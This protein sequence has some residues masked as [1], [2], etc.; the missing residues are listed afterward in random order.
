M[1]S[2]PPRSSAAQ[3]RSGSGQSELR[4]VSGF[5]DDQIVAFANGLLVVLEGAS[6]TAQE[7]DIVLIDRKDLPS[8]GAG[9]TGIV[10]LAPAV[11]NAIF[12]ATGTRL[13]NMPM[14]VS[15]ELTSQRNPFPYSKI[16]FSMTVSG[17]EHEFRHSGRTPNRPEQSP[18][19]IR[20][21]ELL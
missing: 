5:N 18:W 6:A 21:C 13:R 14:A 4:S 1:E 3:R 8:A 11:S 7:I 17:R 9:E 10:G 12:A 20:C 19:I 16:T 2:L 15:G